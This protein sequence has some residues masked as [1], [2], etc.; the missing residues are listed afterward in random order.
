MGNGIATVSVESLKKYDRSGPRYTS[1]P[2][3]PNWVNTVGP[4]DYRKS[5]IRA[6]QRNDE[7]LAV[8]CHIPFCRRR[9]YYCGCNTVITNSSQRVNSYVSDL[10]TE[11]S[12]VAELLGRRKR[13]SQL[14]FGGGTP[15]YLDCEG[16]ALL[17]RHVRSHF[18]FIDNAELSIEIDPRV[19]SVEQLEFLAAGGFNRISMGVQDFDPEVQKA[20]GRIQPLEMIEGLMSH[21]RRLQFKGI[22]FDLIYGLPRQTVDSFTRTI[23]T[24]IAL[25][26][27]RLAVYSF[28]YLPT[29]MPHQTRISPDDLPSTEVKYQLFATAI[30]RFVAAGYQQIGMDHFALPDDELSRAQSDGRL[31]R[32]FM[33]YTV[34]QAPEMIGLGMSAIGYV[35]DSFYQNHSKL[36]SY[37]NAVA[38]RQFAVYRG[39]HLSTDDLIRQYVITQLMCNFRLSFKTLADRFGVGYDEYF[40]GVRDNLRTFF[41]DDL[42]REDGSGMVITPVG[43]TFV[44]NIAMA[45]DAYLDGDARGQAPTFS[46]TI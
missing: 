43:R 3:V 46:R 17:M 6:A 42:I 26:P 45:Y 28:A 12:N 20:C 2:T 19:T 4:E 29:I 35:D 36:D 1:Y 30:E 34:Q 21:C 14:H 38:E 8:Y 11:M 25:H 32:N 39:M 18:E 37:Q 24:A 9:C 33:G 22:N 41:E 44:R 10:L 31:F 23:D 40:A 16:T 7:P 13:I 27:D 5:L 15:T